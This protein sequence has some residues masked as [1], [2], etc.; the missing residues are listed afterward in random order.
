MKE[1]STLQSITI[2]FHAIRLNIM[3]GKL[4]SFI[5]EMKAFVDEPIVA[6]FECCVNIFRATRKFHHQTSFEN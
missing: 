2:S 6:S 4:F 1:L 5:Y 3:T